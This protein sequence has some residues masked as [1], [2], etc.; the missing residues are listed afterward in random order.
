VITGN[1]NPSA[2]KA[3]PGRYHVDGHERTRSAVPKAA[4]GREQLRASQRANGKLRAGA[5]GRGLRNWCKPS[6]GRV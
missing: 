4:T 6:K 5:Y 2:T 3:G 1:K